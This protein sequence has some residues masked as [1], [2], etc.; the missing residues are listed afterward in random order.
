MSSAVCL[1]RVLSQGE[2]IM[3]YVYHRAG[4]CASVVAVFAFLSGLIGCAQ[5]SGSEI[6]EGSSSPPPA[7]SVYVYPPPNLQVYD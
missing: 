2:I 3:E 7:V 5:L 6:S 4:R 1:T